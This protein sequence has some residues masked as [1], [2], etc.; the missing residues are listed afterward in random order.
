MKFLPFGL[1]SLKSLIIAV[2]RERKN[3][4]VFAASTLVTMVLE[5]SLPL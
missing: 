1:R 5:T 3:S 2:R 4:G